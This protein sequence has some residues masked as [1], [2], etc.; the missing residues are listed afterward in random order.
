MA[1]E[2]IKTGK[3]TVYSSHNIEDGAWVTP[4]LMEAQSYAGNDKVYQKE[5]NLTD[6]AWVDGLQGQYAPVLEKGEIVA[7]N[8]NDFHDISFNAIDPILDNN[9]PKG[10]YIE[11]ALEAPDYTYNQFIDRTDLYDKVQED[12]YKELLSNDDVMVNIYARAYEDKFIEVY[13]E[14]S[15]SETAVHVDV[16]LSPDEQQ[17]IYDTL[18]KQTIENSNQTISDMIEDFNK[19]ID[20]HS[21]ELDNKTSEEILVALFDTIEA[22][23]DMLAQLCQYSPEEKTAFEK[24]A[25]EAYKDKSF[26]TD[27]EK[28]RDFKE[29]SKEDFLA[30]HSLTTEE[31]YRATEIVVAKEISDFYKEVEPNAVEAVAVDS[32]FHNILA[33]MENIGVPDTVS[34]FVEEVKAT[35][36]KNHKHEEA[37]KLLYHIDKDTNPAHFLE[38]DSK[39]TPKKIERD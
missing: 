6:I 34:F 8:G 20:P 16:P 17:F 18:N 38:A 32:D 5:V 22:R 12:N 31:E 26:E 2:A 30:K 33:D 13:L 35:G 15:T 21:Y 19:E 10:T 25:Y 11:F 37:N 3:I 4:S 9:S 23:A 39:E 14:Y 29:L 7:E 36:E 27:I 1:R 24:N 28:M